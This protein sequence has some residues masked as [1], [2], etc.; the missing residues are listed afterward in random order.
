MEAEKLGR[1]RQAARHLRRDTAAWGMRP[2]DRELTVHTGCPSME[3]AAGPLDGPRGLGPGSCL[4]G[5]AERPGK[6]FCALILPAGSLAPECLGPGHHCQESR[7]LQGPL[8]DA[9]V[10]ASQLAEEQRARR[11]QPSQEWGRLP[12]LS[13][14]GPVP[15]ALLGLLPP[16]SALPSPPLQPPSATRRAPGCR[17]HAR[18]TDMRTTP[19]LAPRTP[20]SGGVWRVQ[21]TASPPTPTADIAKPPGRTSGCSEHSL[22]DLN[23]SGEQAC[24]HGGHQ[25]Q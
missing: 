18:L 17:P 2:L 5:S 10:I 7:A 19:S 15:A 25:P 11:N 9:H 1:H 12:A 20:P 6:R 3:R 13:P 8:G 14:L 4:A 16:P 22:Q 24:T 21:A 23:T